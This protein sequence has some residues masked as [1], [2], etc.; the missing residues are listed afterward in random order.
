MAHGQWGLYYWEYGT[1]E[2]VH[3]DCKQRKTKHREQ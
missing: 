2:V 1:S 3:F